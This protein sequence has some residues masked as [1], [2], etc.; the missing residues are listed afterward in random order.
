[1]KNK[2][3]YHSFLLLFTFIFSSSNAQ[4]E[5]LISTFEKLTDSIIIN[6]NVPGLI[7]GI[8]DGTKKLE[9]VKAKGKADIN[10]NSSMSVE[11]L[12]R[13]GSITK[14]FT[15]T[16]LLQLVDE[17]KISLDDKLSKY[18]PEI[19]KSDSITLAMLCNMSSGIFDY[20][21]TDEFQQSF[22]TNPQ[23]IWT[24]DEKIVLGVSKSFYFPVG[25]SFHYSNTNTIIIG[26]VIE[27]ITGRKVSEE[28]KERIIDKLGLENT[29]FANGNLL[30]GNYCN[31]YSA[32][33]DSATGIQEDLTEKI[34]VSWI[35]NAGAIVSNVFDLKK[36][37]KA[38]T[39]GTLLTPE[40]QKR[41]LEFIDV[42]LLSFAKYGIGIFSYNGFLGHNGYIPGYNSIM[43]RYPEKD[44]TIIMFYNIQPKNTVNE[45]AIDFIKLL[46]PEI[47]NN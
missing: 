21:E 3:L 10:N 44:C 18:F 7:V 1:M 19:P 38:L 31:G 46:Y 40:T 16:V 37:A 6:T 9:W 25:T 23:R 11:M 5:K 33:P 42:P 2:I 14:T 32:I 26:K 4:N 47:W 30:K 24:D 12:F 39:D 28:I 45:L 15:I 22:K 41:R 43:L 27:K 13:V 34:D 20:V 35:G 17:K 36:Y 29:Y 8:W